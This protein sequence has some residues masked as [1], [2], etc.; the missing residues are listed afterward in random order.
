M[1]KILIIGPS[2][3]GDM[4]M[5]QSL[6]IT[7]K[8][9]HPNST[10]DVIAPAWCKP[11][12]DRMPEIDNAI[13]MP[14]GHG[15]FAF[16]GRRKIGKKL[17]ENNYDQAIVLPNSAKS[18]LIPW[19]ANI[20][21]RTGWKGEMRFGLLNDIRTNK[22]SFQYMVERYVALAHSK[23]E[24]LN[25]SSLGGLS[26]LPTPNLTIQKNTQQETLRKF[27]LENSDKIIGMCPGAEFGPAKQWPVE[28][29]ANVADKMAMQGYQVWLFGS[30]K[31]RT[32][33]TTIKN[34]VSPHLQHKVFSLAGDTSLIEAID[35]LAIC[36]TV[37]SNDSGLMHIAASVGCRVIGLY[38]STSPD[39]TPPLAKD[40]HILHT[41]IECRPCFKRECPLG[42]LKCLK[43][44]SSDRVIDICQQ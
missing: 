18:A 38:G 34:L 22:K 25:S 12:L 42:H 33:T 29:Y 23:K 28:N 16:W 4:V 26:Q 1:Y 7:L 13:T 37:I 11:I 19:F 21:K 44:L 9:L 32:T 8:Q 39:Y 10:I 2:W 30:E 3:V 15:Q 36:N 31:D 17:A 24:M 43:E 6:Y 27:N 5:S 14:F 35:L 41:E 40:V 20:P